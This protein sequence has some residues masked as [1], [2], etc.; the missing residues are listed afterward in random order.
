MNQPITFSFS[1]SYITSGI[2]PDEMKIA[3][4]IHRNN[5]HRMRT[6]LFSHSNFVSTKWRIS[7]GIFTRPNPTGK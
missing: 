4:V 7:K 1:T 3:R 2:V 6:P 5:R